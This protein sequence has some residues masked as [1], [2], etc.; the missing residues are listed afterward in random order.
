M[1]PR[2]LVDSN[3]LIYTLDARPRTIENGRKRSSAELL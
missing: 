2:Y 3:V 1:S